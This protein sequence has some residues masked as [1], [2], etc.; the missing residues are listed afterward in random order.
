M[1]EKLLRIYEELKA[2]GLTAEQ[3]QKILLELYA[4]GSHGLPEDTVLKR[5]S[6]ACVP[7]MNCLNRTNRERK[8]DFL[9]KYVWDG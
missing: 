4:E 9:R 3:E 5:I 7:L 2:T 1:D 6:P 8:T